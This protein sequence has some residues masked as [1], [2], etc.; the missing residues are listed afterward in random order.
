MIAVFEKMNSF[1]VSYITKYD[2]KHEKWVCWDPPS[3]DDK[4]SLPFQITA[5]LIGHA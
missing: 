4:R 5:P 1:V 3:L 2:E